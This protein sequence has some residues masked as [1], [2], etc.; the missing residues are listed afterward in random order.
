MVSNFNLT[1]TPFSRNGYEN[2]VTFVILYV[3]NCIQEHA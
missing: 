1:L 2:M 3:Q